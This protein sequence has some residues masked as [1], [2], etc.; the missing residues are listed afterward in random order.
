MYR[1][2]SRRRKTRARRLRPSQARRYRLSLSLPFHK[3]A[4]VFGK[5]PD[6]LEALALHH[7]ADYADPLPGDLLRGVALVAV[8]LGE[9]RERQVVERP[10][11]ERYGALGY[12]FVIPFWSFHAATCAS[13]TVA[14]AHLGANAAM[15]ESFCEASD[16]SVEVS[17]SSLTNCRMFV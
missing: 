3:R 16:V 13:V 17:L 1:E 4:P 12:F 6:A 11:V 15:I 9:Q 10:Y 5:P 7:H 14:R 2:I 8:D